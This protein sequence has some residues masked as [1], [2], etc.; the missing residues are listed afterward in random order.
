MDRDA[1]THPV[2]ESRMALL[3]ANAAYAHVHSRLGTN[4]PLASLECEYGAV[5]FEAELATTVETSFATFLQELR[6][7]L[8]LLPGCDPAE[9]DADGHRC[10]EMVADAFYNEL[11]RELCAP[12]GCQERL[13]SAAQQT[14]EKTCAHL[15]RRSTDRVA[16]QADGICALQ[17]VCAAAIEERCVATA[18]HAC[19]ARIEVLA[20]QP[21][22]CLREELARV[23]VPFSELQSFFLPSRLP[24]SGAVWELG[25]ECWAEA[26]A[27]RVC[28]ACVTTLHQLRRQGNRGALWRGWDGV[29]LCMQTSFVAAMP[30]YEEGVGFA[31][32]CPVVAHAHAV[33]HV[34]CV[35]TTASTATAI[36]AA[37]LARV[38]RDLVHADVLCHRMVRAEV[39]LALIA[40][41]RCETLFAVGKADADA[42]GDGEPISPRQVNHA[43]AAIDEPR[44]GLPLLSRAANVPPSMLRDYTV[45]C[46]LHECVQDTAV[47]SG[48]AHVTIASIVER[49]LALPRS[50][51]LPSPAFAGVKRASLLQVVGH[52]AAKIVKRMQ[53][54]LEG[55]V[56]G[57]CF[58]AF[59]PDDVA[60]VAMPTHSGGGRGLRF[61]RPG[62]QGLLACLAQTAANMQLP[63][64]AVFAN[65]W[66]ALRAAKSR[67]GRKWGERKPGARVVKRGAGTKR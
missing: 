61:S 27:E 35:C 34:V 63:G 18:L 29:D 52:L 57:P 48:N 8:A 59:V 11:R 31:V 3:A 49:L 58:C 46:V 67:A 42:G 17:A 21:P 10:A 54:S 25:V 6:H 56:A 53:A 39:A 15:H 22:A 12:G 28:A 2:L 19:G 41:F 37:R 64:G 62:R 38:V 55:A 33:E 44:A 36:P 65:A 51:T 26:Y 60:Y 23:G 7:A 43:L 14:Y 9:K 5:I 47:A 32:R 40:R 66:H 50:E 4:V 16:Q 20:Q 13:R 45:L 30:R 24:L 1:A